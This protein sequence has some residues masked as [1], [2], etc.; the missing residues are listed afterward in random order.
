MDTVAC[1]C[2]QQCWHMVV[3]ASKHSSTSTPNKKQK[4]QCSVWIGDKWIS[5]LSSYLQFWKIERQKIS[6]L[7]LKW[8]PG[9]EQTECGTFHRRLHNSS[10]HTHFTT[11]SNQSNKSKISNQSYSSHRFSFNHWKFGFFFLLQIIDDPVTVYVVN[12]WIVFEP[13]L[14]WIFVY[15]TSA[16]PNPKQTSYTYNNM[17]KKETWRLSLAIRYKSCFYNEPTNC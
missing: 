10:N 9:T 17:N 1:C 15:L 7:F 5:P 2:F 13:D 6:I 4:E 3:V 8:T 14:I 12:I 16:K 11:P